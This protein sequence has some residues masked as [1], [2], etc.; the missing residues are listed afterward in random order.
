MQLTRES[1]DQLTREAF[2]ICENINIRLKYSYIEK[3]YFRTYWFLMKMLETSALLLLCIND[4][5]KKNAFMIIKKKQNNFFYYCGIIQLI[6]VLIFSSRKKKIHTT[7]SHLSLIVR[8]LQIWFKETMMLYF[9]KLIVNLKKNKH[10]IQ[11]V[12][13]THDYINM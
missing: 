13:N 5:L 9:I 10:D 2:Y 1:I 7:G 3:L 12:S 8:V 6:F 4:Y 11:F